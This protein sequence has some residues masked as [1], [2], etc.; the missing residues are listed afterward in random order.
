MKAEEMGLDT[1]VLI[2]MTQIQSLIH[3][4]VWNCE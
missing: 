2:W 3:E 1:F 4:K